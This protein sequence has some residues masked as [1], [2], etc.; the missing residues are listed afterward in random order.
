MSHS[1]RKPVSFV[2]C[3]A[4]PKTGKQVTSR[5]L[6]RKVRQALHADEDEFDF[7]RPADKNRGRAGS[8]SS[9]FG[10]DFFGDGKIGPWHIRRWFSEDTKEKWLARASRK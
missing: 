10:W 4:D 7:V 2:A 6:R 5:F 1:I 8:R 3:G 9:D